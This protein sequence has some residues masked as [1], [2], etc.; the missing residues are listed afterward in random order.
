MDTYHD[1]QIPNISAIRPWSTKQNLGS[2]VERWLNGV[3]E[4]LLSIA[5]VR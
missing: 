5:F 3:A 2:M 1:T 4:W